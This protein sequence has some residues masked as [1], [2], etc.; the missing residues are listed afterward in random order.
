MDMTSRAGKR[1][2]TKGLSTDNG[3]R[4]KIITSYTHVTKLMPLPTYYQ[5]NINVRL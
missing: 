2:V 3:S 5:N 4:R 1:V